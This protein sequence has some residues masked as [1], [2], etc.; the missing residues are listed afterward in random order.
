MS[1]VIV[2]AYRFRCNSGASGAY[3]CTYDMVTWRDAG[4]GQVRGVKV[5]ISR[6]ACHTEQLE[7]IEYHGH[8]T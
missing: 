5:Q 8:T 2:Y 3:Y 1:Y 4:H 7:D 6:M